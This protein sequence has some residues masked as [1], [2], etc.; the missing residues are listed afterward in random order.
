MFVNYLIVALRNLWKHKSFT[1]IN[2]AGLAVGMSI[3]LLSL[4]YVTN[5]LSFDRFHSKKD[6]IHRLIVKTESV[7]E[8]TQTSS[9]MTAGVGPSFHQGIPEVEAMVRIT[10]PTG[11]FLT[12]ENINY[13]ARQIVYADSSFFNV[14]SFPVLI[15]NPESSLKDPFNMVLTKSLAR[16]IFRD[17][18]AAIG[19]IVRFNDKDNYIVTGIVEDPPVNSHLRFDVLLSFVSLYQDPQMHLEWNG[20]WNYFTYLLLYEGADIQHVEDQFVPIAEENINRDMRD[21]GVSWNFFLQRLTKVHLNTNVDWDISSQG[22]KTM[23]ILFIAITFIILIIACINFINLTTAAALTRMKEV[24]VRKVAGADRRQIIY[25]FLSESMLVSLIA[26]IH[27]IIL[28]EVFYM[29]LS[30]QIG[31]TLFL[32]NFELYNRSFFQLAGAIL[33]LIVAVGLLAGAYPAIY[34]SNFRPAL[35]VKGKITFDKK[36]PVIRN[37]L[38][39][40]Q[41]T[42]SIILIICTLVIAT[43]LDYLLKSDKGF[44]PERK[45]V[46]SLSTE[47]ARDNV[48]GLKESFLS[49]PGVEKAGASSNIPGQGFTMNGYFPEGHDKPLMFHALDVDYDYLPAMGLMIVQ[50]RNFSKEFGQEDEAYIINQA[51]AKQLGWNEPVGKTIRRGND[52]K[53][54]GVVKDFNFSPLHVAIEPLIITLKPWR[55][56][57]HITLQVSD[58][59][60]DLINRLEAEWKSVVPY[61]GF[62]EFSLNSYVIEAYG[63]EKLY[64]YM[65]LFCAC[66]TIFIAALGLF[67]LAAFIT[68]RRYKEIAVRKVFGAGMNRIFMLISTGFIKWVLLA[69]IIAIP[70]A[71]LIMDNYFLANFAY[72]GGIRWWIFIAAL[73]F[74]VTISLLVILFQII[75]L[76]RLNPIEYIRY[77]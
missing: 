43:Q 33:F 66:L 28:I 69:N 58:I 48:E 23:L 71:Y 73:L 49:I 65:I 36:N 1:F 53:I 25:Q 52:H 31:D 17:E 2:I 20:G 57:S 37:L 67:G 22:S 29:W 42:I 76:G 54:I 68:R 44:D 19:K 12:I 11:G 13:D 74:S 50:G 70:L 32:E 30:N 41:F 64:M 51:L 9:V 24:G 40:F 16:K 3:T 45:I 55:G 26:V 60:K 34:M 47:S 5:E 21:I 61:E 62:E 14:F 4:L 8:G 75:R 10:N 7:V 46:I 59:N 6:R 15:G 77:E 72:N 39:V 56:Y 63:T 38:V 35:A 18:N 27:A